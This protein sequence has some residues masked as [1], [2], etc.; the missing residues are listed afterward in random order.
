[1]R[2]RFHG[3]PKGLQHMEAKWLVALDV[4]RTVLTDDYRILP[5]VRDA[6]ARTRADAVLVALATA[7]APGAVRHVLAELGEVDAVV[8]C[9]GALIMSHSA[10]GWQI[11][12]G[13]DHPFVPVDM[14]RLVVQQARAMNVP[15]AA[16]TANGVYVDRMEPVLADEFRLT[17]M[18]AEQRDLMKL[19]T[20]VAKLLAVARLGEEAILHDLRQVFDRSLSCVFSHGNLLEIMQTGVSKGK[21][22]LRLSESL[23]IVTENVVAIGDSE[24]DLSMFA[25]AGLT[26]AMGNGIEEIKATANWV[27]STNNEAGVAA[28]LSRCRRELW[29]R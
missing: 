27:T 12:P 23:G 4:D 16:Y 3:F 11:N 5:E 26:I 7:R 1:M 24:N 19:T 29:R 20:P 15:L 13:T 17:G 18:E 21:A 22:L 10:A 6:V 25:A 14:V 8:C 28:A 2:K 9:G